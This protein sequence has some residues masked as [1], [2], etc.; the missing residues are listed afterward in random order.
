MVPRTTEG[1][2][3]YT[4]SSMARKKDPWD[5]DQGGADSCVGVFSVRTPVQ[6]L[7]VDSC[8]GVPSGRNV[9]SADSCKGVY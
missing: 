7:L 4:G 5:G 1:W 6:E 3:H 8:V 2:A 9:A